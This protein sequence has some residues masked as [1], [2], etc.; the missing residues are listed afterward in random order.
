MAI[1]EYKDYKGV[2]ITR[3]TNVYGEQVC[4]GNGQG[5]GTFW[6]KTVDDAKRFIDKYFEKIEVRG[7]FSQVFGLIPPALCQDCQN[8]YSFQTKE[9]RNTK[10]NNCFDYKEQL[11]AE[12]NG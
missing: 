5:C 1:I 11:K 9:W 7:L 6:F 4:L 3:D 8:H 2:R 10:P 12:V